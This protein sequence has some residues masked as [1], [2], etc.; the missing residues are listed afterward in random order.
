MKLLI[1]RCSGCI[2]AITDSPAIPER[3]APTAEQASRRRVLF[4]FP[5]LQ[6]VSPG[7]MHPG[8]SASGGGAISIRPL[9]AGLSVP[10]LSARGQ[11]LGPICGGAI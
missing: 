7:A 10:L 8:S 9:S 6:V 3:G 5:S 2:P 4:S 1:S 11:R